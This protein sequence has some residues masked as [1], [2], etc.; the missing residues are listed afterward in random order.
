MGRIQ[1]SN[2][3]R[4]PGTVAAAEFGSARGRKGQR[5]A[6]NELLQE[7]TQQTV[8]RNHPTS[9]PNEAGVAAITASQ[10]GGRLVPAPP[11][12]D[13]SDAAIALV[14]CTQSGY[15]ES[16]GFTQMR[17]KCASIR[18]IIG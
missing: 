17:Y 11:L 1:R 16:F 10:N 3:D 12:N 7:I 15:S 2:C 8:H 4:L 14:H 5:A 13:N 9:D 18:V 6:A